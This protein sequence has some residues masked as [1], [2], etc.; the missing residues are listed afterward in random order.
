MTTTPVS[1]AGQAAPASYAGTIPWDENAR[2]EVLS[3]DLGQEVFALEAVLVREILDL[4]PETP[5][6]GAMPL[7]GSVVNFRGK[8]IPIADLRLAFGMPASEP[9]PDSRI[10]VIEMAL[11]GEAIQLGIRTDKVHEVATLHQG[12]SE[13]PPA[14]GMQWKRDFVRTL[15]R[16]THSIIV[17][18]N[19][20]HIFR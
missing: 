13:D 20:Q 18:P 6:P 10:V 14:V 2:I 4:L 16:T 8:I 15:V 3:F 17:I 7:V 12:D 11:D 19:I 9:T 1:P 5:V